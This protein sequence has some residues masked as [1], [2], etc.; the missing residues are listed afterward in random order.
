MPWLMRPVAFVDFLLTP[1]RWAPPALQAWAARFSAEL[2]RDSL[3]LARRLGRMFAWVSRL[4]AAMLRDRP[5]LQR[6]AWFVRQQIWAA[7]WSFIVV[8]RLWP[9]RTAVPRA[10]VPVRLITAP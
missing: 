1:R 7:V 3:P 4:R 2:T 10:D 9:R 5:G 8:S 6:V